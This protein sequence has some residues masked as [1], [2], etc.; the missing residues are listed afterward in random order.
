M[1][2][3]KTEIIA[4]MSWLEGFDLAMMRGAVQVWT[5]EN[6]TDGHRVVELI[7]DTDNRKI[8]RFWD[9]DT[10]AQAYLDFIPNLDQVISYEIINPS[11]V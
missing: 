11:Q 9:S 1:F 6:K 8:S 10:S 2:N 7:P 5:S 4:D 3:V